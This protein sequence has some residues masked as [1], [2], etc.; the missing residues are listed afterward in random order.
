VV[1]ALIAVGSLLI[2]LV[3]GLLIFFVI[4]PVTTV[5]DGRIELDGGRV[6]RAKQDIKT[7][8]AAVDAFLVEHGIYPDTLEPLTISQDG[9]RPLLAPEN[10]I[11]PWNRPYSYDP[12]QQHPVTGRP[13]ISSLGANEDPGSMISNW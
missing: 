4:A 9:K 7:L 1:I 5:R 13:K 11:D 10:L 6:D 12:G 2:V 8:E 3:S